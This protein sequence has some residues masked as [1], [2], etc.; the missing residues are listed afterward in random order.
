MLAPA[1][2]SGEIRERLA[3]EVAKSLGKP[4][5]RERLAAMGATPVGN[6]PEEF[7]AHIRREGLKWA[8]AVKESGARVD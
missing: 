6:T 7:G 3:R 8:K 1:G 4:D 5:M 2:T